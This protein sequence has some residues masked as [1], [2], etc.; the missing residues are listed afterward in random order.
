MREKFFEKKIFRL[1]PQTFE[2]ENN[3]TEGRKAAR[4][5]EELKKV[6][7]FCVIPVNID[8]KNIVFE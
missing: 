2:K 8:L 3:S 6:L 7:L 5:K 4:C 1:E